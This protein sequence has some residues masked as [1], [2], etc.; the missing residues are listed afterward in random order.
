MATLERPEPNGNGRR[1]APWWVRWVAF[2]VGAGA[3]SWALAAIVNGGRPGKATN[4]GGQEA[5]YVSP[6]AAPPADARERRGAAWDY[7]DDE[8]EG[9]QGLFEW[10]HDR[11]EGG[12]EWED[13]DDRG[14]WRG[15]VAAAPVPGTP[16]ART[17]PS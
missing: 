1:R 3:F 12:W 15:P 2:I 5:P 13:D 14:T 7:E 9:G 10:H 16:D 11:E 17:R 8:M 6:P 4:P